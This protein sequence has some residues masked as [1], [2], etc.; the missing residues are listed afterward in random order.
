MFLTPL[1]PILREE[2]LGALFGNSSFVGCD[3]IAIRP[4]R[5]CRDGIYIRD[6]NSKS[7][8][9][10]VGLIRV[11]NIRVKRKAAIGRHFFFTRICP[12]RMKTV[13]TESQRTGRD[14]I[15]TYKRRIAEQL[16]DKMRSE[17]RQGLQ[18]SQQ[19]HE[20][21]KHDKTNAKTDTDDEHRLNG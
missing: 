13:A 2:R 16:G 3:S 21:S 8:D 17:L 10:H 1:A 5:L 19:R 20:Q 12:T 14:G 11:G 4:L 6:G 15:A 18:Q 9:T 7:I